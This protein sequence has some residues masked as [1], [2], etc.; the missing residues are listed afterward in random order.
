MPTILQ[1][2]LGRPDDTPAGDAFERRL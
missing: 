1:A 2:F